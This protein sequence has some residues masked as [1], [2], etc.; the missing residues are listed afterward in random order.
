MIPIESNLNYDLK[1]VSEWL[2]SNRLYLN[3]GK[4]KLLIFRSQKK[5]IPLNSI[6]IK[7]QGVKIK[8]ST[9]VKYLGVFIDENLSWNTHIKELSNKLS[10]ANGIISKLRY[11]APKSSILSVY[12][13]IFYSHIVYGCPVWSLTSKGNIDTINILQKKC[14][15]LMN[16][17]PYN[18]HTIT[19]F[20]DN[21]IL[22]LEDII[23]ANKLKLGFDFK[24]NSLPEDLLNMFQFSCDVHKHKTRSVANDGLF[25]PSVKSTTYGINTLKYSVPVTW[26]S[27]SMLNPPSL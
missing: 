18:S 5:K 17:A 2:K 25:V 12:Y 15:R 10:R 27:F 26:N 9:H 3:V 22:K 8:P 19:L 4:T 7:I 6:S 23:T 24:T 14:V 13:A 21:E 1:L 11:Y 16:F 20:A